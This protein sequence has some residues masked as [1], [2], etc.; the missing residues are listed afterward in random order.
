MLIDKETLGLGAIY[1]YNYNTDTLLIISVH[2]F[3][4]I[5]IKH[6]AILGGDFNTMTDKD[7]DMRTKVMEKLK[8]LTEAG[9]LKDAYNTTNKKGK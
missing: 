5:N 9:F 8:E 6:D 3:Q 2:F 7:L 1:D 4:E